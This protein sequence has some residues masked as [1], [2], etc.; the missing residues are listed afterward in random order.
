MFAS[1]YKKNCKY[2]LPVIINI[3]KTNREVHSALGSFFLINAEGWFFTAA[4]VFQFQEDF[5]RKPNDI[6]H[7]SY[8][9]GYDQLV[10]EK[11]IIFK[12]NDL[13]LCK[14]RNFDPSL[15]SEY[16]VFKR[17]EDLMPGTSLCKLGF[18]FYEVKADFIESSHSFRLNAGVLPVPFFP[19]EGIFTRNIVI[20]KP[21]IPRAKYIETSSPGLKGQSGGPI[22][23]TKGQVWAVQS[24]TV[25][26]ALGFAPTVNNQ[27]QAVTE[28]QFLNVGYG[29]HPEVMWHMMQQH[30]VSFLVEELPT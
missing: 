3:R 17:P 15:C 6:S 12:E 29:V 22:F 28:N 4:H 14:F 25:H 27:D 23:D 16:P 21:E 8:W 10:L 5:N 24:Q 19:L 13:A 11:T 30:Q 1:A 20:E 26:L 7:I 2:T 9:W 18:P